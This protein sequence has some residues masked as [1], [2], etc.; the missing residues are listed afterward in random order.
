VLDC[1]AGEERVTLVGPIAHLEDQERVEVSGRWTHDARYGP[2]V[3]VQSAI[4]LPPAG[5]VA[6]A[7]Y[8][9]RVKHVGARR[10]E[11]LLEQ[12]GERVL[13]AIDR[14]PA[15]AFAQIGLAPRR[16]A[17]AAA[18]WDA[19]RAVRELHL[20]LAPHGLAY[21]VTRVHREY[22]D[23]AHRAVRSDPYGLTSV[24]GVGFQIADRI[25][26]GLGVDPEDP[27]RKRAA[28]L[29]ALGDA[30]RDGSTCLPRAELTS[31]AVDLLGLDALP[32]TLADELASAGDLVILEDEWVYRRETA[33]LEAELADRVA[34]LLA[35]EPGPALGEV[36]ASARVARDGDELTETQWAGVQAAFTER[37][38]IIT[39]GPGTGK[40][41]SIGRSSRSP[42]RR[43]CASCSQPRPA[44]RQCA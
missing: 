17:E 30:E 15:A 36:R 39:G 31:N 24:F 26:R 12:H 2:Q 16:A 6:I 28:I 44:V 34:A 18:S 40:T 37:L 5:D 27:A 14:D 13:S 19:L 32:P 10:A 8:L 42:R 7:D 3:K 21:L 4:P 22:G 25:A 9:R 43:S 23:G 41:A 1:T 29:H 20:L 11:K 38:S 35:G 33:E